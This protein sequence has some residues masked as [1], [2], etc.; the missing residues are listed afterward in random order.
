M[1]L[2]PASSVC[3]R[4]K[5]VLRDLNIL[6][7]CMDQASGSCYPGPAR[8]PVTID[9]WL[10]CR[11]PP[12]GIYMSVILVPLYE[13]NRPVTINSFSLSITENWATTSH[14]TFYWLV[15]W[16]ISQQSTPV[17]LLSQYRLVESDCPVRSTRPQQIEKQP[18]DCLYWDLHQQRTYILHHWAT[19]CFTAIMLDRMLSWPSDRRGMYTGLTITYTMAEMNS[20]VAH[21]HQHN[22]KSHTTASKLSGFSC[23]PC[24]DISTSRLVAPYTHFNIF[25]I[26]S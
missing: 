6:N 7:S 22:F 15:D 9:P 24:R 14:R 26:S 25:H 3:N 10:L 2:T 11:A 12:L 1:Y 20:F 21:G 16:P 8:P 13:P 23:G 18:V 5:P 19:S 17:W 4:Q